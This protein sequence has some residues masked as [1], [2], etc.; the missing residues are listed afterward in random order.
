MS[1]IY[2]FA[3]VSYEPNLDLGLQVIES[4]SLSTLNL[5]KNIFL[6]VL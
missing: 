1:I 6:N 4:N 2:S 3:V 5:N